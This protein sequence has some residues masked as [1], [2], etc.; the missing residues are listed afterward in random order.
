MIETLSEVPI[1]VSIDEKIPLSY[2]EKSAI[3]LIVETSSMN[4]LTIT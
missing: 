2:R 4:N 3:V 1:E